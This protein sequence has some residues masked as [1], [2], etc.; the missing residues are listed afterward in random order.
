M[1]SD[2]FKRLKPLLEGL[3]RLAG[4]RDG[5]R[6]GLRK[7]GEEFGRKQGASETC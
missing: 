5:G 1:T 4:E 3:M 7:G 6:E 2:T